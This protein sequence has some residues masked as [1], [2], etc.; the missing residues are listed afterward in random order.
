MFYAV[1]CRPIVDDGANIKK[2]NLLS[3]QGQQRFDKQD[4]TYSSDGR[5]DQ[6]TKI[7]LT[8]YVEVGHTDQLLGGAGKNN[9][10]NFRLPKQITVRTLSCHSLSVIDAGGQDDNP[11]PQRH[12]QSSLLLVR[13]V[14]SPGNH[15]ILRN[16]DPSSSYG[17]PCLVLHLWLMQRIERFWKAI[18][19]YFSEFNVVRNQVR[20]KLV[21]QREKPTQ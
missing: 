12:P 11:Q 8:S 1:N 15:T 5:K 2:S 9:A 16:H 17:T 7:S 19:R 6:Q 20:V 21:K 18:P 3:R 13:Q 4:R 10:S 14:I